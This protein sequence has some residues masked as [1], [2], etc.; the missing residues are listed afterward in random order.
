MT[1]CLCA[2]DAGRRSDSDP[3]RDS[4][5][6]QG[7]FRA[8]S[9]QPRVSGE[10]AEQKGRLERKGRS[11]QIHASEAPANLRSQAPKA[12]PRGRARVLLAP[13]DQPRRGTSAPLSLAHSFPLGSLSPSSLT[14]RALLTPPLAAL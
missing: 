13:C 4:N 7:L 2:V 14:V 12:A 1:A 10:R 5:E 11:W 9:G 8:A 3:L 6:A